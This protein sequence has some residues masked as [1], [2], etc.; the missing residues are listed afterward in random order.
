MGVGR[1]FR[2]PDFN[3][4]G[5]MSRRL[6]APIAIFSFGVLSFVALLATRP[7]VERVEPEV[8][9]PLVR[10]ALVETG[11]LRLEVQAHGT[12]EPPIESA[13]RAQVE[14]EIV[15]VSPGLSPGGFFEPDEPLARLDPTDYENEL[16]AAKAERDRAT[17]AL[18]V[19]TREHERQRELSSRLA[20]SVARADEARD[21]YQ[22]AEAMLR[23]AEIR[24]AH[25]EHDLVRTE[26]RAPFAG[27]TRRKQVDIGQFVR[28]GDDL[29]LLYSIASAE[30]PLPLSDRELAYLDLPAPFRGTVGGRGAATGELAEG[31]PVTL[32][33]RF[34]GAQNEW[35]GQLVRTSAEIDP[36]SRTVTVVARVEDPYGRVPGGP[37]TPLPVGLF[38]EA[39]IQGRTV[40]RAVQLPT[41]VLHEQ[42]LVYVIDATDRLHFRRV[43]VLRNEEDVIIV[44]AELENGERVVTSPLRGAVEGMTVRVAVEPS[45]TAALAK[46]AP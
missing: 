20:T 34:A 22:A 4:E 15:W 41:T 27:R 9:P 19:A 43:E 38:V 5:S 36:R 29:A 1:T 31:P 26:I 23:E 44:G 11:P 14:G 35:T 21:A 8:I 3:P 39:R 30:V 42:D 10:V 6:F 7:Q 24:V 46:R 45:S 17:S 2:P 28:R 25:A 37:T 16:E 12:V 18:S 13:L 32:R 33:A 40:P